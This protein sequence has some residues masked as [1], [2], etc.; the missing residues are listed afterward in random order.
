MKTIRLPDDTRQ[1][2]QR[3]LGIRICAL[4]FLLLGEALLFYVA[5][6]YLM[7]GFGIPN[8]LAIFLGATLLVFHLLGLTKWVL[9]RPWQGIVESIYVES[10][11]G[12][13]PHGLDAGKRIRH[14]NEIQLILRREDGSTVTKRFSG[15]REICREGDAV[16]HF[17]GLPYELVLRDG[18]NEEGGCPVC[19]ANNPTEIRCH[20]CGHTV[21]R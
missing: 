17:R 3:W 5:G 8:T 19:G 4:L 14:R 21:I 18:V 7:A 20:H 12:A 1:M 2:R 13:D 10:V 6:D 15:K 16:Y 11:W 9:D